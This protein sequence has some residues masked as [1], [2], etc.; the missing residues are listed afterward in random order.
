VVGGAGYNTIH[1]CLAL[2]VPLIARPWPRKYDRQEL[3]AARAARSGKVTVVESPEEAARAACQ[4]AFSTRPAGIDF[5]NGATEAAELLLHQYP[6]TPTR[7]LPA[8][9]R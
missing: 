4:A 2:G 6:C 9:C 5:R 3:R 8:K 7:T 1:E